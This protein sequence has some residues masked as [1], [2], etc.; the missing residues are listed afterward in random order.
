[1]L[2]P[3]DYHMVWTLWA[4]DRQVGEPLARSTSG[5]VD[6]MIKAGRLLYG[7]Q[8]LEQW[9]DA[10]TLPVEIG[11]NPEVYELMD[12]DPLLFDNARFATWAVSQGMEEG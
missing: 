3:D 10:N 12:V 7:E 1:M 6:L 11:Y 5:P 9:L 8:E 4:L 2:D